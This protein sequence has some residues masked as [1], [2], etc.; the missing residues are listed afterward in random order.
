MFLVLLISL[1]FLTFSASSSVIFCK[2]NKR[3]FVIEFESHYVLSLYGRVPQKINFL[4]LFAVAVIISP[5]LARGKYS[6]HP[7]KKIVLCGRV[8]VF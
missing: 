4:S 2:L 6:T 8:G 5:T 1:N 7:L 3:T